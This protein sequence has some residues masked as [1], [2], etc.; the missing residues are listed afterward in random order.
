MQRIQV[1]IHE[2][3]P[4]FHNGSKSARFF[5]DRNTGQILLDFDGLMLDDLGD[6]IRHVLE[7]DPIRFVQIDSIGSRETMRMMKEFIDNDP[8]PTACQDLKEALESGRP[9]QN[10]RNVVGAYPE[11]AERW[12]EFEQKYTENLAREWLRQNKVDAELVI[13][14]PETPEEAER[15]VE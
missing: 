13:P 9:F 4:A 5:L 11:L 1:N 8:N 14:E 7:E 15:A 12:F 3:V 6:D 10:F 2:L